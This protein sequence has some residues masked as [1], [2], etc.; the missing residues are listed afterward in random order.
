VRIAQV[1][2]YDICCPSGVQKHIRDISAALRELGHGVPTIAP[3]SKHS[4]MAEQPDVE[5]LHFG[6]SGVVH[7]NKI[8]FELT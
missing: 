4:V 3:R 1:C 6:H 5:F 2:P 8:S 7:R